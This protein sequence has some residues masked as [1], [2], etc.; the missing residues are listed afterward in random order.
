MMWWLFLLLLL[1]F[2]SQWIF[3]VSTNI[4]FSKHFGIHD[5]FIFFYNSFM[6]RIG[7]GRNSIK[8]TELIATCSEGYVFLVFFG[9]LSRVKNFI[10]VFHG[11]CVMIEVNF[12]YFCL[13]SLSFWVIKKSAS[14]ILLWCFLIIDDESLNLLSWER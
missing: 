4:I 8:L 12:N 1:S 9:C 13:F 14:S 2:V 6:C 3:F 10:N 11:F 7:K 5:Y